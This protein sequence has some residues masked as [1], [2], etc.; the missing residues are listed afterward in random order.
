MGKLRPDEGPSFDMVLLPV[1]ERE[2][3]VA[4]RKRGTYWLRFFAAL[5]V[6]LS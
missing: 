6:T 2:L 3:R 4:A 5:A 1:V